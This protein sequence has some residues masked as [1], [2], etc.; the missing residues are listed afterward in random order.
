[1]GKRHRKQPPIKPEPVLSPKEHVARL[2]MLVRPSLETMLGMMAQGH[3]G[4]AL[5]TAFLYGT[6]QGIQ[7]AKHDMKSAKAIEQGITE[8]FGDSQTE[9]SVKGKS[10][11]EAQH[12]VKQAVKPK[13]PDIW[14]PGGEV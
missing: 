3:P 4:T 1:M 12:E 5:E 13:R 10:M 9:V 2:L 7:I 6:G 8:L 11:E 14:T